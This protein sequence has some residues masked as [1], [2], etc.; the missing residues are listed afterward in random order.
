MTSHMV[1]ET[2]STKVPRDF[3]VLD[4]KGRSIG[5]TVWLREVGMAEGK[6]A[7]GSYY[8]MA[9]GHY[10]VM[11]VQATRA[12]VAYGACQQR[13]YFKTEAERDAA[14]E[15]YFRE[16]AKRAAKREGK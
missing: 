15:K 9:P 11:T 12:G 16:A 6:S 1:L 2:P 14:V 8:N 5:A 7:H 10:F 3:G 13:Q 4:R